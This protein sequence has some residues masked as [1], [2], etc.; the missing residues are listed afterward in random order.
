MPQRIG[1]LPGLDL[2][3]NWHPALQ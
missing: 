1:T 2:F 3:M